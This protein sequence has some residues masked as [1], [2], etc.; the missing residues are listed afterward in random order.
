MKLF[1]NKFSQFLIIQDNN[2]YFNIKKV[3]LTGFTKL[4]DLGT[5]LFKN[6]V[7]LFL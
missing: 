3:L 2:E 5:V 7:L 4:H 1:R 6:Y